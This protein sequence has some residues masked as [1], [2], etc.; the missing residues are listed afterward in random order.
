MSH[1]I[2]VGYPDQATAKNVLH[3]VDPTAPTW[4]QPPSAG[5][6]N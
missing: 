5:A 6:T 1:L 4:E 3:G 2:V